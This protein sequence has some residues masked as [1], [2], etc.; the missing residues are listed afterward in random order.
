MH[1]NLYWIA[2]IH[3]PIMNNLSFCKEPMTCIFCS[4]LDALKSCTMKMIWVEW[5]NQYQC[6]KGITRGQWNLT[7]LHQILLFGAQS[8]QEGHWTPT[9]GIPKIS[10]WIVLYVNEQGFMR[11]RGLGKK[12]ISCGRVRSVGNFLLDLSMRSWS[13][14]MVKPCFFKRNLVS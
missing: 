5:S 1:Y 6:I 14:R 11:G 3:E 12:M 10:S 8:Q 9:L 2:Q 13:R 4:I 7:L